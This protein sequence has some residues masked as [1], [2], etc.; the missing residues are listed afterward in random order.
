MLGFETLK[1]IFTSSP[2]LAQWDPDR[3][4]QI[5]T[6]ASGYCSGGTL[7]Q[8]DD[9]GFF[10][11][12]AYYSKR[13][14]PAECNYEIYD[15][16]MLAVIRALETWDAELRSVNSFR[17]ITDHKNLEYFMT[18]R[19]LTERQMRWSLVLSKFNFTIAY[20]PGKSND[21]A[22]ALSRRGQDFPEGE[23]D[24]RQRLRL[25]Q[26][27]KDEQVE[28][29]TAAP[30]T[31]V[32]ST[33]L[34]L[35]APAS[36]EEQ[37]EEAINEDERYQLA[38]ECV[39]RGDRVFPKEAGF[40]VAIA[41]CS[42][43]DDRLCYRE[44]LWVPNSEELR[45]RIL[46]TTHDSHLTGHPGKENMSA[47][48]RRKYFW[49]NMHTDVK[50]FVRNCHSCGAHTVWRDRKKGLLRPLPVP[51]QVWSEISMDYITDLPTT[52]RKNRHVLVIV[53][54][55]SKGTIFIPCKDLT[56]E[57]LARKITKYYLPHHL[58]PTAITSDRGD[59][60]VQGIW[61]HVCR[62]L[63]IEQRLSTAFH[64]ETDGSTE[65]MNQVLEE[66]LRH[67]G[68]YYQD[69]WDQNLPLAQAAVMTR[70]AASTGVSPFFLTHGY[71]P[72]TGSELTGIQLL[73]RLETRSKRPGMSSQNYSRYRTSAKQQWHTPN[74]SNKIPQIGNEI[75]HL[76]SA[77]AIKRGSTYVILRQ[78]DQRRSWLSSTP[79]LPLL[80]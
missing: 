7:M 49:P 77:W 24:D 70:D 12:V 80:R 36:F 55:L 62:L 41:D 51:E 52:T 34:T 31:H 39:K 65:R 46:Q 11:P 28:R 38:K 69:D 37:W 43:A 20:R 25:H 56:G 57:T 6:D 29:Q 76:F 58:L 64:P 35:S 19:K 13:H 3:E 27:L 40:R 33:R 72:R 17:I 14:S 67:F 44:R 1:E 66:Y 4:T 22:D 79:S 8:K 71:H 16:E 50:R 61:G 32:A 68:N 74:R 9:E 23:D 78:T 45:T 18:T 54:R 47:I 21:A 15:K 53:D 63:G 60:F 5:E 2:V 75:Q 42:V 48:L 73:R 30:S 10:R 26:L 59:Q